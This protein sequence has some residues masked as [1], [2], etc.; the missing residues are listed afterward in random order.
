MSLQKRAASGAF[1][2]KFQDLPQYVLPRGSCRA[3]KAT[4]DSASR[5]GHKWSEFAPGHRQDPSSNHNLVHWWNVSYSQLS[6]YNLHQLTVSG[7]R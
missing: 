4:P 5:R 3:C 1:G 2:F 6:L 7:L